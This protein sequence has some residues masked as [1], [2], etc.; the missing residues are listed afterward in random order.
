MG[1]GGMGLQDK[2]V[3][4]QTVYT[5]HEQRQFKGCKR[6]ARTE[7]RVGESLGTPQLKRRDYK[8]PVPVPSKL[9]NLWCGL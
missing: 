3:G 5:L 9:W 7:C 2:N 6:H 8:Y 1:I 4:R